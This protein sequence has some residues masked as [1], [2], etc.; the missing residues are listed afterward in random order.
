MP[1]PELSVVVPCHN[2][3]RNLAE[4]HRR[5]GEVCRELFVTYELVLVNDGSTDASRDALNELVRLDER[6]VV[7]HFSRNFGQQAALTAGLNV[8]RGER[9]L[10]LD[11]DLQDPPELLPEM[12]NRMDAG[13]DVVYGMRRSRTGETWIKRL[14]A[15]GFYRVVNWLSDTTI[16]R[17]SGEF[18]LLSRRVVEQVLR[19]PE[20]HRFLRGMVAWVGFRQEPVEYDRPPR[21]HGFSSYSWRSMVELATDA[22]TAFSI[23]PLRLA[24]L[25]TVLTATLSLVLFAMS[26]AIWSATSQVPGW[27]VVVATASGLSGLHLLVLGIM[28]EYLGR[29]FEQAQGRPLYVVDEIVRGG[30]SPVE[31][32]P[33]RGTRH[34]DVLVE[35]IVSQDTLSVVRSER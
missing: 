35:D 25:L 6:V 3:A 4:L 22:F 2:E 28:G 24:M 5:V 7:V 33:I 1:T 14:T 26:L 34:A 15:A 8:S 32:L 10:V 9:V 31:G 21:R 23:R 29:L 17:N 16:P 18:R 27:L 19:M 20:R 12:W 11:A 30:Q 13:A